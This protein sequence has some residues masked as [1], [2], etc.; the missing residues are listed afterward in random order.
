MRKRNI[1]GE[2]KPYVSGT[3]VSVSYQLPY[4]LKDVYHIKEISKEARYDL[5]FLSFPRLIR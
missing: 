5:S 3:F 2:K 1:F 4:R